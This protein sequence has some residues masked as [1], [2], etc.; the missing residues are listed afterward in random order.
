MP[1]YRR[2]PLAY[3][4][5]AK[6]GVDFNNPALVNG[7]LRFSGISTGIGSN[8]SSAPCGFNQIFPFFQKGT[9]TSTV[10][11]DVDGIIGPVVSTTAGATTNRVA[12]PGN[13][14]ATDASMILG[15]IFRVPASFSAIQ[16]IAF[17]GDNANVGLFTSATGVIQAGIA[18]VTT[19]SSGFTA[20]A[21]RSYFV[22]ASI[23]TGLHRFVIRDLETGAI[24]TSTAATAITMPAMTGIVNILNS[25]NNAAGFGGSVATF[26][27]HNGWAGTQELVMWAQD[28]WRF[29]YPTKDSVIRAGMMPLSTLTLAPTLL[30]RI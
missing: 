25:G 2:N 27:F 18:F 6:P 7:T 5:G 24:F 14:T 20:V 13:T 28:P 10:N 22:A 1:I 21:N 17:S 4:A 29:W 12:L 15:C 11:S 3:P 19:V 30:F 16:Y 8:A 26:M 9:A 23:K